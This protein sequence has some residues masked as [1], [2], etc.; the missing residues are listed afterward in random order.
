M[1]TGIDISKQKPLHGDP[2]TVHQI[3]FNVNL[4]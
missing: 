4:L 2:K 3:N 1:S